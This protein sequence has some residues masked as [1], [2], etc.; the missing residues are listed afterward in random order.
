MHFYFDKRNSSPKE[1][2]T[3]PSAPVSRLRY[4]FQTNANGDIPVV[5]DFLTAVNALCD[6]PELF[7]QTEHVYGQMSTRMSQ[8]QFMDCLHEKAHNWNSSFFI[9]HN[10]LSVANI[11]A[12]L[13]LC[14]CCNSPGYLK[15]TNPAGRSFFKICIPEFIEAEA[16]A[17]AL[18]KIAVVPEEDQYL[19]KDKDFVPFH[20]RLDPDPSSYPLTQNQLISLFANSQSKEIKF[21]FNLQ[22]SGITLQNSLLIKNIQVE[23]GFMMCQ[24]LGGGF[25]IS[26]KAIQKIEYL[27]KDGFKTLFLLGP[28]RSILFEIKPESNSVDTWDTLLEAVLNHN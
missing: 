7:I 28:S 24:G 12:K 26:L 13:E 8:D 11:T 22:S 16:W 1:N 23:N 4:C 2:L 9:D 10:N 18:A 20:P 17:S 15:F 27:V 5:P 3:F 14:E 19:S 25:N 6:F 21:K